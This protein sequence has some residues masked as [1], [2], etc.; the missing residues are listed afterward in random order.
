L[1]HLGSFIFMIALTFFWV[2]LY[3]IMANYVAK[4]YAG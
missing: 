1:T 3:T 4:Q 2:R